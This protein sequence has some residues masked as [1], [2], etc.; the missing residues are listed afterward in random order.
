MKRDR[1]SV[2][3]DTTTCKIYSAEYAQ[4]SMQH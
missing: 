4:E 1:L 2:S 3:R